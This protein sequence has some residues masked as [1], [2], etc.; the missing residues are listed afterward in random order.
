[1]DRTLELAKQLIERPSVT[2]N[3]AGCLELLAERLRPLGFEIHRLRFDNV[4]NLWAEHGNTAPLVVFAGHTDVV[5]PGPLDSWRSPPFEPTVRDGRLYGRGAADMK[6]S[7]AAFV[8]AIEDFL[9]DHPAHPGSIGILL[10]SDEEGP[11]VN[12]TVKVVDWLTARGT[13]IDYCVVG[14][15]T[16]S[17][18][19]G[20]VIKNGRRGSLGARLT[21]RGIQGHV[22]Y[23]Q[24]ARNPI[25]AVAPALAELVAAQWDM[26]NEDFP[27]TTFQ[28]SNI[29]AGTGADNVIPGTLELD[30][31]FRFSTAS[32]DTELRE[33]VESV[34]K[35]HKIDYAIEWRLSG[36][37]YLT[38]RGKLVQASQQAVRDVL[39]VQAR[40]STDGGT[41]DG[42]FIAPTGAEVVELGPPNASIHKL[43]ENIL[44]EDLARLARVYQTL[45][46][47]LLNV[48]S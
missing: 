8:T 6:S 24:T 19:L 41:S 35:H 43:D 17:Q 9:I 47:L 29:H 3:D 36:R 11:A 26:G 14:E 1:M 25:H 34:L 37:P 21:V 33:R 38:R 18:T 32:T 23:P 15:P 22:A 45:L 28:V 20:D 5:P 27:P 12:G 10:T 46:K 7:V 39:G 42:R 2:P 40:L 4:D 31:N 48:K 13:R 30:F 44:L 16:G